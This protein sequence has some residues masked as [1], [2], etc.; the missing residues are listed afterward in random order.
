[1]LFN[2]KLQDMAIVFMVADLDRTE[3]FYRD[4][5]D[6]A[7]ERDGEGEFTYLQTRLMNGA[8]TLVFFQGDSKSGTT[9][10]IVFGLDKGGIDDLADSLARGGVT[11]ITGVTEAPGGWSVDFEDPDGHTLSFFQEGDKPRRL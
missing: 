2:S 5:V 8:V 9:P 7:L 4:V 6:I 3:R 10:Q 1:M 11:L